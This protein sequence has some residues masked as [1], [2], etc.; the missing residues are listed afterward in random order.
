MGVKIGKKRKNQIQNKQGDEEEKVELPPIIRS[1]DEPPPKKVS[2]VLKLYLQVRLYHIIDG[3]VIL[4]C[5][6]V[7]NLIVSAIRFDSNIYTV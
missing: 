3:K 5:F 2:L 7:Q 1:S 4:V 6:S